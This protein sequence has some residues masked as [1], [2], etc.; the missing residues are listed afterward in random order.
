MNFLS[1]EIISVGN[2][3]M[4]LIGRL[5]D[6]PK[7]DEKTLLNDFGK[8]P[9]GGG[10]N[11]A[12]ACKKVGLS[13]KFVGCVGN[14]S[15]GNEVLKDLEETGV[16]TSNV[17]KVDSSTGL[18]FIFLTPEYERLLIE[19]RGANSYLK[20]SDIGEK[21][22]KSAEMIHASSVS[23]E[24][25]KNIGKK[26]SRVGINSSL[27]LG[28]ELTRVDKEELLGILEFFDVCFMNGETFEDIFQ[29]KANC[30]NILKHF[31]PGLKNFVI[32]L[33]SEG[34]VAT[35]NNV[36]VSCP[37]FEVKSKDTTGAGDVFAAVFDKYYLENTPLKKTVRYATAAAAIKVQYMGARNGQPSE[38]E[39]KKFV[40]SRG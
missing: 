9:G 40:K 11:F 32:T 31:P 30:E 8:Y 1:K 24:L 23:P 19:H 4:D 34:A 6:I 14:D 15:F 20:T 38:K 18:A 33:G 21:N 12:A 35:D 28:A 16:D 22:L 3:N 27:D 2:L 13:S 36:T 7:S 25:A 10:A 39:I 29:E 26:A 37:K 5:Q 17:K